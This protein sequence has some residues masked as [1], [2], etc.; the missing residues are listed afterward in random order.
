MKRIL[1]IDIETTGFSHSEDYITEIGIV[2]LNYETGERILLFD[3]VVFE[4]KMTLEKIL[5]RSKLKGLEFDLNIFSD[6]VNFETIKTDIQLFIDMYPRGITA[7]NNKFDFGFLENRGII[8]H[9]KL[10]DP[11]L[12]GTNICKIPNQN[13]YGGYKWPKVQEIWDYLFGK[14]EY[15]ENHRAGDDAMHEALIVYELYKMGLFKC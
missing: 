7:Y 12:L 11:M 10:E 4:S 14:T 8:I 3:K 13:G 1:V 5:K 9:K 2:E 6:S 15:I